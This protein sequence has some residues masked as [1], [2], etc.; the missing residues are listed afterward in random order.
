MEILISWAVLTLG[1]FLASKLLSRMSIE[2]GIGSHL[3]V[4]AVFGLILALTGWVFT[5]VL[6]VLSL[7]LL[8]FFSFLAQVLVGAIVLKITDAV[9]ERLR[10]DGFGT[11]LLAALI[12]SLTG[13]A[14]RAIMHFA[15]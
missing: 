7:G 15:S 10:V 1:M 12:I 3:L 5:L 11:A 14:A 6:G 13:T 2:G 4:S 9:F 8:F